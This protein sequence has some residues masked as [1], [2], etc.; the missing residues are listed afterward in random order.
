[1]LV[2]CLILTFAAEIQWSLTV[3]NEHAASTADFLQGVQGVA[4]A[5]RQLH[6]VFEN[7]KGTAPD[8]KKLEFAVLRL[9]RAAVSQKEGSA[10]YQAFMFTE[11]GSGDAGRAVKART[12]EDTLAAVLAEMQVAN[13][14]LSAA[15]SVGEEKA[16][17]NPQLL[18]EAVRGLER[19][20]ATLENTLGSP[21]GEAAEPGRFGFTETTPA[22][23]IASANL[24]DAVGAF[25]KGT[26]KAL[27]A[28]VAESQGVATKV[29]DALKKLDGDK[30]LAVL[31]TLGQKLQELPKVGYLWRLGVEKLQWV[32]TALARLLGTDALTKVREKVE[33][34]WKDASRKASTRKPPSC[35]HSAW[36]A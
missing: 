10:P 30:I 34:I 4:Q 3:A 32:L 15:N 8:P 9:Q 33:K 13:V 27:D 24:P 16:K 6:R 25:R 28:F 23:T 26:A 29:F 35:G 21:L 20:S 12:S 7:S 14:L 2:N 36:T 1:M 17:P 31:G 19:T 5:G 11:L 18:D 22:Q